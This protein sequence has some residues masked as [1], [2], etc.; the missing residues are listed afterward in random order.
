M[1]PIIKVFQTLFDSFDWDSVLI[2]LA[3]SYLGYLSLS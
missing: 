3:T 2:S 1:E